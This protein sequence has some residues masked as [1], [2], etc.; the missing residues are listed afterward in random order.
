MSLQV[1]L[2]WFFSIAMLVSGALVIT[3]HNAVNSAM[4]LIQLFL[5]T[6]GLFLLL[7]AFFLAMVQVLVYAGAVMVLFL[8]VIMLL[9]VDPAQE[10]TFPRI[11]VSGATALAVVLGLE[12]FILLR[13]PIPLP[14]AGTAE[15]KGGLR[16]VLR[17]LFTDYLLPFE[18]TALIALV[19]MIGVIVLSKRETA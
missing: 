1:I 12:F 9:D 18:L 7:E 13:R 10:K 16:E 2:F 19:A 3:R 6:A 8:F 5:C 11:A 4:F 14:D 15:L 17:P